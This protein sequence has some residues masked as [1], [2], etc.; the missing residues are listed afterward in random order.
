MNVKKIFD[1]IFEPVD[2]Q[3]EAE[4][5]IVDKPLKR[6]EFKEEVKPKKV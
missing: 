3:E 4:E 6:H 5:V 1:L 2:E